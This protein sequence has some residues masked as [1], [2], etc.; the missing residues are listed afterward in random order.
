MWASLAMLVVLPVPLTPTTRMTPG[1]GGFLTSL[2]QEPMSGTD[3]RMFM[4]LVFEDAADLVGV[5]DV[6]LLDPLEE[7]LRT[8][9]VVRTPTSAPRRTSSSSSQSSSSILPRSRMPVI[10]PN[11][12]FSFG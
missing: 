3:S 1:F 11:Q 10:L 7:R 2:P 6:L 9:S 4:L 12:F 5:A 8:L